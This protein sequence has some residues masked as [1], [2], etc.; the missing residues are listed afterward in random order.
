MPG[1]NGVRCLEGKSVTDRIRILLL[2]ETLWLGGAQ[3]LLP[4]LVTG[5][6]P[7][8]FEGHIV[9]LHDGPLRQEFEAARL[10]LTVLGARRFYEPRVVSAIARL[11]RAQQIDV[12]HTHLTGADIVGRMVGAL[13]GVPVV[14]TMHNVPHDYDHQKWHRRALQ[15]LTARTLAARLVMVAPG[16]GVEYVRRWG[17][18]ASRV[19]TINNSVP[20]EPYLAI[21]EGVA[22]HV[23]PTVTTIGRLTEQKA[24]HLLLDAARLVVRI[25]PDTRFR[26]V[27]EGRLEAA[28]RRQA[29]DLGIARAVSFDGLRHDIPD[30]LAETHVFVLSSLWEG[31]PVTAVEAMAAARPVVLTD[32]GGCRTLV[33]PGVEGWLVPPGNVEALAAALL[34]ALD[35]PERQRL[36]GR[37]GR[38]KVR[39]A[40]GLEQYVRGHEQLYESLAVVRAQA[41][42]ARLHR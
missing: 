24:Y 31:L 12:I 32:V 27:G 21:A 16:I 33:T 37:R 4:G 38:E 39:R 25:R 8:R 23:P 15:R 22:P 36:F 19:V 34:D 5:L 17:I 41:R 9:A 2:I 30:I 29:Q 26:M 3:R 18:P 10:P 42:V 7:L 35:N 40:F 11:V 28:L 20:M 1:F 6:D 14:S 13:T